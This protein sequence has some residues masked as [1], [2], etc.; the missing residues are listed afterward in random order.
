MNRR[1]KIQIKH[2]TRGTQKWW[3]VVVG[4]NGEIMVTSEKFGSRSDCKR[5]CVRFL[6]VMQSLGDDD[7]EEM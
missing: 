4:G 1:A 5:R 7:F 2:S 6:N 3:Y